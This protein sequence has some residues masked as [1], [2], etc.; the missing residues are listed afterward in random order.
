MKPW[1]KA[2]LY[3]C[4][5]GVSILLLLVFIIHLSYGGRISKAD[6]TAVSEAVVAASEDLGSMKEADVQMIKRLYNLTPSDYEGV[7]LYYPTTNMGAEEIFLIKLKDVSQSAAVQEAIQN[8][9]AAQMASFDGYG[10]TQY[11]ML[12]NSVTLVEGNYILY[13]VSPDPEPVRKA[14]LNAI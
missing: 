12:E 14:F 7:L 4:I 2:I 9:T 6:F 10:L 1:N 11:A 13:V 8:R 5:K 3:P